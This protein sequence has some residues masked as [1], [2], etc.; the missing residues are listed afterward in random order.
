MSV[1]V[2]TLDR[3]IGYILLAAGGSRRFGGDK[4]ASKIDGQT[5]LQRAVDVADAAG[6][7][8]RILVVSPLRTQHS[9][10]GW[11]MV[12]NHNSRK[13]MATSVIAGLN[14]ATDI[15]RAVIG[16]ADMPLVQ[17]THLR[18]LALAEGVVFT[19]QANGNKG[20]PAACPERSFDELRT[21]RGDR[22]AGSLHWPD[23]RTIPVANRN[24]LHDID[25]PD[26]L[27]TARVMRG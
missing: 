12:V 17:P 9:F 18:A 2:P 16:L 3:S 19:Q 1:C 11:E 7:E 24:Q 6:F 5:L 4:L 14:R 27:I 8:R 13:G 22:G 26:D 25:T 20:A 23:A 10:P 21:L 15:T